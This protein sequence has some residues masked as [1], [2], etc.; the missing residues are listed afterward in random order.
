MSY[1]KIGIV[2]ADEGEYEPFCE[3]IKTKTGQNTPFR[4]SMSF[5]MGRTP[6]IAVCCGIGKVNAAAAAMFLI[7][8][9]CDLI[10]NFGLSGGPA[11][12]KRGQLVFPDRFLEYDFDLTPLGYKLC[13]KPG[14]TYVYNADKSLICTLENKCNINR[15]S[16]AVCGDRFVSSS[17]DRE[18]LINTFSASSCDM[19]TAAIASVC[20]LSGIPF[21][22]LRRISDD[23]GESASDSYDNM[24]KN[25]GDTLA[26]A[27]LKC[28]EV[29]CREE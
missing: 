29:I 28:L 10:L 27:F 3:L 9:G 17:A 14:Q 24:N 5:K 25:E 23:A 21:L 7:D 16:A 13:E 15:S 26:G 20:H 6:I 8:G 19:E 1:K 12:V 22:S 4:K 18:F 2:I 11:G